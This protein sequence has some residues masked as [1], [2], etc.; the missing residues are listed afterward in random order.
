[1]GDP[2]AGSQIKLDETHSGGYV[3]LAI[4]YLKHIIIKQLKQ[5]QNS[6]PRFR[7]PSDD[8]MTGFVLTAVV[9]EVGGGGAVLR[10]VI[11]VSV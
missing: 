2:I 11:Q 4:L 3:R 10:R 6:N 9:C 7:L 5:I 8:M 1:M